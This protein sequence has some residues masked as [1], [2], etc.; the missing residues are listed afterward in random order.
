MN[1]CGVHARRGMAHMGWHVLACPAGPE[2]CRAHQEDVGDRHR[3]VPR[4]AQSAQRVCRDAMALQRKVQQRAVQRC[5][6]TPSWQ[7]DGRRMHALE[8]SAQAPASP[9]EPTSAMVA[10]PAA[11]SAA[12]ATSAHR[13][14]GLR[15][16]SITSPRNRNLAMASGPDEA[17]QGHQ[18]ARPRS[19]CL[20][21]YWMPSTSISSMPLRYMQSSAST[22]SCAD[23]PLSS[24]TSVQEHGQ[25]QHG[26]CGGQR[27]GEDRESFENLHQSGRS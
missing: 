26:Q 23:G 20:L 15:A 21:P 4:T 1:D 7:A 10:S 17:E 11:G 24:R 25:C 3:D 19:S 27:P 18:Q 13:A 16:H 14:R 22:L 8:I 5:T 6:S 12:M 9:S 2:Q